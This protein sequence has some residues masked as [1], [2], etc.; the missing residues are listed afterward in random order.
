[1]TTAAIIVAAG[2]GLRLGG[3]VPK[4]YQDLG[5]APVLTRTM[6][7]LLA[8]GRIDRILTVIHPDYRDM[9]D[10]AVAGLDAERLLP[11]VPGGAERA[12]SVR[13]GL[14]ALVPLGSNPRADP[15][16]RQALC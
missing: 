2:R 3:P 15:R 11:P 7:A 12:E 5:G 4:Q 13:L 10:R 9:Y 8:S 6:Q 16:C 14:E 1:M